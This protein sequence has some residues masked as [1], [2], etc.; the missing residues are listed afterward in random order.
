MWE[1]TAATR[2]AAPVS[3]RQPAGPQQLHDLCVAK[4]EQ[5]K[6]HFVAA[7]AD[8]LLLDGFVIKVEE[9]AHDLGN[10]DYYY[11]PPIGR[12]FRSMKEV[13]AA[14]GF[15]VCGGFWFS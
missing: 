5:L 12:R 4:L 13:A 14:F 2:G 1:P 15:E 9:R 3:T 6:E 7:G 8:P 10:F 11:H